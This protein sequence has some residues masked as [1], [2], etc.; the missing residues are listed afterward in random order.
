[1]HGREDPRPGSDARVDRVAQPDVDEVFGADVAH[2]GEAGFQRAPRVERGVQRLLGGEA[3]H[4][5]VE[6]VVVVLL[7]L[8]GEVRVRVD[9]ARQDRGIAQVDEARAGRHR[10][11]DR[12]DVI[13][14]HDDD[15]VALEL[16]AGR[17]EH[18][19]GLECDGFRRRGVGLR[20]SDA[21]QYGGDGA[22]GELAQRVLLDVRHGG[23]PEKAVRQSRRRLA[24][25]AIA[26]PRAGCVPWRQPGGVRWCVRLRSARARP[27]PA[28][29]GSPR[30][31]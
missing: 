16:R 8:H 30:A 3:H 11:A 15:R 1:M 6:E 22:E 10:G 19:R 2:G 28:C 9:E 14:A 23:I 17:V 18:A 5:G 29:T 4:A 12:D 31:A 27:A 25:E 21:E 24:A 26:R 13:P 20:R 7:E